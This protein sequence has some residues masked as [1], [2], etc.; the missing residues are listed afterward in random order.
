MSLVLGLGASLRMSATLRRSVAARRSRFCEASLKTDVRNA[1]L[2]EQHTMGPFIGASGRAYGP[3]PID[4]DQGFPQAFGLVFAGQTYSF[5]LYVNASPAL[6]EDKT[7]VLDLPF[8]NTG[9]PRV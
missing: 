2:A 7:H 1:T 6:L 9:P 4:G 3:L 5:R 8:P